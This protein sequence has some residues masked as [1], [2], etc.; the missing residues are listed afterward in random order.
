MGSCK[1]DVVSS[2]FQPS[3]VKCIAGLLHMKAT[4]GGVSFLSEPMVFVAH[5]K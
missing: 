3:L 4:I 2:L 1:H 5:W